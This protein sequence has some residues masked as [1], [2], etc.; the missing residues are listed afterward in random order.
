MANIF[1]N[2]EITAIL[3]F[4]GS[5]YILIEDIFSNIVILFKIF[6]NTFICSTLNLRSKP[7]SKIAD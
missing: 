6:F 3:L 2:F 1:T 5:Y 4:F 7:K